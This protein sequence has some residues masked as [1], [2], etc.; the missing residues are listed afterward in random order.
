V[1]Q[2]TLDALADDPLP[3]RLLRLMAWYAPEAV[4]R[5]LVDGFDGSRKP[6]INRAIGRLAAYNMV[7]V[8]P[9]TGGVTVHRLVQAVARTPDDDHVHRRTADITTAYGDAVSMLTAVLPDDWRDPAS[10]PVW[11]AV[12]PHLDAATTHPRSLLPVTE[13]S[14]AEA[15]LCNEA[16]MFLLDQGSLTQA[17]AHLQQALTGYRR[18][19]GDNH[20]NTLTSVNNLAA[21]YQTAGD[22][23]RAIPLYEQALA[24]S[25]RVLDDDHPDTLNSVSNLAGAYLAAGDLDRA[26]PLCDKA[27]TDR[28]RVLGDHHPLTR[29]VS[30]NT[31]AAIRSRK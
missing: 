8:D 13:S 31:D 17:I 25:R 27:L 9:A 20:P 19:L 6:A 18:V 14:T 10:W 5:L 11:R 1:W 7:T 2:V 26:I 22:L 16:G 21:A 3:G 15:Y 23:D 24:D 28:R 4:P 29:V 30:A 12:L